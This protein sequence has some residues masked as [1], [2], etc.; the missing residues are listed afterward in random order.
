M[1]KIKLGIIGCGLA[2]KNLHYPALQELK[3]K[4]EIVAVSNHT[5]P[6]AKE[7]SSMVGG[8]PY[9]LDYKDLL[10]KE[11]I[12]AID[13]ALPI[14][15][16]YLA[17]KDALEAGKHVILEKPLGANLEEAAKML[18]FTSKYKTVMLLAENFRY[19][20]LY[21]RIK[22]I[23]DS[24]SIGKPSVFIWYTFDHVHENE[25]GQ[26]EWRRHHQFKGGFITDGGVHS[27]AA[28]RLLFGEVTPVS[29]LVQSINPDVGKVDTFNLQMKFENDVT[30]SLILFFS[31]PYEYE[32]RLVIFGDKGSVAADGD[33]ITLKTYS[34]NKL[35]GKKKEIKEEIKTGNGFKEE[36]EDFYYAIRNGTKI[37][38]TFE[39]GYKDLKTILDSLSM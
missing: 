30:G 27:I 28:I 17:T 3:D 4:F 20:R 24:G 1:E 9:F 13:I 14:D 5:E 7:F 34:S 35:L 39:E 33:I 12:E 25:Y 6:K 23:I 36:F 11:S 8:V 2:A 16:N 22:E 31:T 15:L 37:K 29:A 18:E 10:K 21:N 32:N 38:S 19:K 26:I